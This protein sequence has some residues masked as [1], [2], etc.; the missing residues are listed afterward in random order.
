MTPLPKPKIVYLGPENGRQKAASILEPAFDL[1]APPP[2]P[3]PFEREFKDCLAFLDASMKVPLTAETISRATRL[4]VIVTATTGASHIDGHALAERGIP[5]LT[6]AGQTELLRNITPAAELS[7]LLL[8]ACA[9]RLKPALRHVDQGG[10]ERTLFPG[11]MLRGRTLGIIGCGRLGSW[12]VRYG[13]AFGMELLGFDPLL[14]DFPPGVRPVS[15]EELLAGSDFITLHVHLSKETENLLGPEEMALI[16][17]GA[18]L[19]N[20]SRAE[21]VDSTALVQALEEGRLAGCGV[22]VLYSEPEIEKDPLW[23]YARDSDKVIITPHIGGFSP[24]AVEKV[25]DFSARRLLRFLGEG[26]HG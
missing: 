26:A 10:W 18:V 8:L 9:R 7:W 19:I 1:T 25:V 3:E 22:D 2:E 15:L 17:D 6:L 5:L 4:K 14:E 12:M 24:D 11:T 21:L 20:T 13:Q 23:L 16:K